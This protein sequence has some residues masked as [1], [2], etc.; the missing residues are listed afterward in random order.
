MSK[1]R[2]EARFEASQEK[3]LVL[4]STIGEVLGVVQAVIK[5]QQ[6]PQI[7]TGPAGVYGN[8]RS[9]KNAE[10]RLVQSI[11]LINGTTFPYQPRKF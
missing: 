11:D 9:M 4:A 6:K 8:I 7:E 2:E 1:Y 3:D 5:E 10:L